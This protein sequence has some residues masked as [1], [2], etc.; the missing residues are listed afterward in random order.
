MV[1]FFDKYAQRTK[2]LNDLV[3]TAKKFHPRGGFGPKIKHEE[4]VEDVIK[5]LGDPDQRVLI[6]L[7]LRL[8]HDDGFA[9]GYYGD[10]EEL[11]RQ[12][13]KQKP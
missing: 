9:T 1:D 5:Y 7:A 4:L 11:I 2:K 8:A 13:E 10:D 6:S 12:L 3:D